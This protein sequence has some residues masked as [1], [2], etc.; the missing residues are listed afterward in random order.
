MENL[1]CSKPQ[2]P[3]GLTGTPAQ[4]SERERGRPYMVVALHMQAWHLHLADSEVGSEMGTPERPQV[5]TIISATRLRYPAR[6]S[7]CDL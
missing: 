4:K 3:I 1:C 5:K 7:L 2:V 6:G